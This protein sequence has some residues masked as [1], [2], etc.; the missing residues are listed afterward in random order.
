MSEPSASGNAMQL[1]THQT[2]T[3]EQLALASGFHASALAKEAGVS[4]RTVQRFFRRRHGVTVTA[5]LRVLRLRM[6]Y[7]RLQC[8]HSV[9]EVAFDLGYRHQ[10]NFTRDFKRQY[11]VPP[12]VLCN[13]SES[14]ESVMFPRV[15]APSIASTQPLFSIFT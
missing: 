6:A 1:S 9:K 8:S 4:L 3:W 10:S 2:K 15:V 14:K 12:S 5:W 13:Q 7:D 11:G